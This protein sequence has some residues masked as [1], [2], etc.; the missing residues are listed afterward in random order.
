[1]T[2][3]EPLAALRRD[4]GEWRAGQAALEQAVEAWRSDPSMAAVLAAMERFAAGETLEQCRA[5]AA[6]FDPDGGAAALLVDRFVAGTLLALDAHPLGQM[7]LPY[8][9]G[10][11]VAML[12]LA[13][14]GSASLTLSCFDGSELARTGPRTTVV[15]EPVESWSR[16]VA[17]SGQGE[18][19]SCAS[20]PGSEGVSL[21]SRPLVLDCNSVHHRTGTH[22]KLHVRAVGTSMLVLRLQR[23]IGGVPIVREYAL[24]DG[25][26]VHRAAFDA[27]D[28]QLELAMATLRAMGRH[29]GVAGMR[30]IALGRGELSLR[31]QALRE[32]LAL[33]LE[34]GLGAIC[35]IEAAPD[36]PLV[37]Q[38]GALRSAVEGLG[39]EAREVA[40]WRN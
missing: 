4:D 12:V 9:P 22:E 25:R 5:L 16:V 19:L 28:S 20:V 23:A 40:S 35:E 2:L 33:D 15:F 7:P 37:A 30:A 1:M 39:D 8:A 18:L 11:V 3:R 32:L 26:L 21:H 29:D 38:V 10:E 31:W 14:C 13:R 6:L 24:S 17:G 36:D 34:A 27:S